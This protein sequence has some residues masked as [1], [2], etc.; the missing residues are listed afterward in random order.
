[1]KNKK[2]KLASA[3]LSCTLAALVPSFAGCKSGPDLSRYDKNKIVEISMWN[4]GG[5]TRYVQNLI[6]RYM[7]LH[8]DTYLSIT[9]SGNMNTFYDT[10]TAG[11][12][13]TTFDLYFSY[14]P[15]YRQYFEGQHKNG[16]YLEDLSGVLN[17][18][19]EGET[20]TIKSKFSK[21]VLEEIAVGDKVYAMPWI[22]YGSGLVYNVNEF[23]NHSEWQLPRTTNELRTLALQIKE[24]GKTPFLHNKSNYWEYLWT[25]W[26]AQYSGTSAYNEMFKENFYTYFDA[27]S[28]DGWDT[29][30]D[31]VDPGVEKALD[32][33][34]S[35]V[36]PEGYT[37]DGSNSTDH[38][39]LQTL[40]LG[41]EAM[42]MPNGGWL[43]TEMSKNGTDL[44]D[45][46]FRIM[47]TPVF[48]GVV[49]VLELD[50]EEKLI[51]VIDYV[52]DGEKGEKPV[53]ISDEDIDR[54]REMRNLTY[55][56]GM[57]TNAFIPSYAEG[58]ETAKDF[59]KFVYSQEGAEIILETNHLV[60]LWYKGDIGEIDTSKWSNFS[61]SNIE[62]QASAVYV[63]KSYVHPIFYNT[64]RT[65][66]FYE[67]PEMKFTASYA[68][69]R[70]KVSAFLSR[71]IGQLKKDW[72]Q[73]KMTAGLSGN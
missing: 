11:V 46:N 32:C 3:L 25:V 28:K 19:P 35:L 61:K 6:D 20:E 56:S 5:G 48:S 18:V 71:E 22:T 10:I 21:D 53:G 63:Y 44:S 33:L 17:A 14:G 64:S 24:D 26:W 47:K 23:E 41:G 27:M 34:Y 70:E 73:L 67:S 29:E 58:K 52:D 16:N 36:S 72:A 1:M 65:N 31:Y 62:K 4:S 7:E 8:P 15:K 9:P 68:G 13:A 57:E 38:T 69:D 39:I 40:F 54:V 43:E 55:T 37:L 49:D 60:P 42:M 59:L 50:T 45:K 2:M 30:A 51:A 66:V 12:R